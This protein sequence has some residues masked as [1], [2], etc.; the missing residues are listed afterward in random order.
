MKYGFLELVILHLAAVLAPMF[1]YLWLYARLANANFY[2]GASLGISLAQILLLVDTLFAH[3]KRE[4][5]LKNKKPINFK[6]VLTGWITLYMRLREKIKK[7]QPH[8]AVL[9]KRV[10]PFFSVKVIQQLSVIKSEE[11]PPPLLI[12]FN[13]LCLASSLCTWHT[14]SN[15]KYLNSGESNIAKD[16][17]FKRRSMNKSRASKRYWRWRRRQR[18]YGNYFALKVPFGGG[19]KS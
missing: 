7:Y 5:F 11:A 10:F 3:T 9:W 17:V 16:G 6:V 8:F 4:F 15:S 13:K 2:F 1:S 12:P 14:R 18:A 19:A